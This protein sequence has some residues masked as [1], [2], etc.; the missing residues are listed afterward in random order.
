[1]NRRTFFMGLL[2]LPAAIVTAVKQHS[3]STIKHHGQLSLIN[4][5]ETN[6]KR[7]AWEHPTEQDGFAPRKTG[8]IQ[9]TDEC[10]SAPGDEGFKR[11]LRLWTKPL[12]GRDAAGLWEHGGAVYMRITNKNK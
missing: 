6:S 4:N 7:K 1:M 5:M 11:S 10:Y 12:I 2:A 9:R 8:K 3:V